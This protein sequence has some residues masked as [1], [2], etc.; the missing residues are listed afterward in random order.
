MAFQLQLS[1]P[2][3]PLFDV[4]TATADDIV[5]CLE[6]KSVTS[7][8]VVWSYLTQIQTHNIDRAKCYAV[9]CM[10]DEDRLMEIADRLDE[11]RRQGHLRG[12]L[13]GVP[14]L[15]KD[16]IA[17]EGKNLMTTAGSSAL[18][19]S[20]TNNS[21]LVE[22]LI[23]RGLII[24]GKTNMTE[25]CMKGVSGWSPLGWMCQP[26]YIPKGY[27]VGEGPRGETS[28]GGS[29]TGSA[30]GVACGFAPISV[31]TETYGTVATPAAAASLYSL[32]LT[33]GSVPMEGI[34]QLTASLD[35][36][37][38]FGKTALDVALACDAL[39]TSSEGPTLASFVSSM[40]FEDVSVGFVDLKKWRLP[41]HIQKFGPKYF[42]QI[43]REYKQAKD[44]LRESGVRVFDVWLTPPEE[45]MVDGMFI[46][47]LM[48][49]IMMSQGKNG[50]ERFLQGFNA[51]Q[52]RTL[53][54]VIK[55]HNKW[56][57][58]ECPEGY[59]HDQSMLEALIKESKPDHEISKWLEGCKRW[60]STNG[61][62]RVMAE[63]GIDVV[64]C[65]SDSLFA[66]VSVAARYPMAEI[67]LG[68]IES[69]GRPYGLQAIAKAHQEPKLVKFMAACERVFPRRRVPD[70]EACEKARKHLGGWRPRTGWYT[71]SAPAKFV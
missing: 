12:P 22:N 14:I 68:Y 45:Y 5:K 60:A 4:L 55:L 21:P 39:A 31:G 7:R 9:L 30:V 42:E 57:Q 53:E 28:P 46:N 35:T 16:N 27:R 11:E 64:V 48:R 25:L 67:P 62:D 32:K 20:S 71:P 50:I 38:T 37:S 17:T 26:A 23:N 51:S 6:S 18:V 44:M 40:E 3:P 33:P 36:V 2:R 19:P 47:S 61:V 59:C 49:K 66:G 1:K 52:A 58:I 34:L 43:D 56:D 13:H 41:A 24:I 29:S 8:Q 65:C 63:K 54:G 10:D 15:L 70:M 69:S